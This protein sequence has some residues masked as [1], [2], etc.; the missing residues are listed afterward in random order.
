MRVSANKLAALSRAR[1]RSLAARSRPRP[2]PIRRTTSRRSFR[3]RPATPTTSPRASCSS[4]SA[5]RW[6]RPIVIDNRGGRRR[7]HRRRRGGAGHAGRLH[8]PVPFGLVQRGLRHAQDAALRHVQRFHRGRRG[9]HP[10]ERARR[11]AVEG[12]QD[13]RRPDRRRQ[14]QARRDELRLGRDRRGLASGGGEI[15]RRRRHQGPA[16]SVQGPGR[17]ADRGDGGAHRLLFP[18]ARAGD[19]AD[20]GRQ[21][22][23]AGG[24]LRQA[25]AVAAGR[26]DHG[27]DRIAE[28]GLCV[29]E[30]RVRSGEDAAGHRRT[31]STTRRRRRSP[32]RA[33]R[34]GWRSSASSRWRCRSRNS[35]KYFKADVRDTDALAKAAGIEKQ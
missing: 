28:G 8:D 31:S 13:R 10:A 19:C 2:R 24:Q 25:R 11:R 17:G 33:S 9:R 34:S 29:L 20:Q 22:H 4:R 14:G 32:I 5:S 35:T 16:R 21:G 30:R 6:G 1:R 23:G 26:A 7:H 27:R 15:Q 18:A 3:S 12:L